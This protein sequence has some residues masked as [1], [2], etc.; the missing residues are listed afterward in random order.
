[1]ATKTAV[2][3]ATAALRQ[4]NKLAAE[5]TISAADSDL[6]IGVYQAKLEDWSEEGLVY[7][8]YDATPQVV[9]QT[10]VELVWNEVSPAFG[11]PNPVEQKYQ[12]ETLLL[13]RLRRHVG[14][15]TSGFQ[16]KAVYY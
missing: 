5:E 6:I 15:R 2:E 4:Y 3:L 11:V 13:K 10:L 9:F 14:R 12:R 7:W 8:T 16:T 1:M